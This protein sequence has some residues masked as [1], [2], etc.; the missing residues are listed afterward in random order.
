M[1]TI[2]RLESNT[3][4]SIFVKISETTFRSLNLW[5]LGYNKS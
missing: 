4:T 2:N 3:D 5:S 1:K